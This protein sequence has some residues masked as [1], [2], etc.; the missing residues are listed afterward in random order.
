MVKRGTFVVFALALTGLSACG[1]LVQDSE[2]AANEQIKEVSAAFRPEGKRPDLPIL[3]PDSSYAD[4]LKYALLNSPVVEASYY[5]WA[6]AVSRITVARSLPDPRL[7]FQLDIQRIIPS[8][9]PGVAFDIPGPGKLAA[10]ADMAAAGS[11]GQYQLFIKATLQT[12]FDLQKVCREL[13]FLKVKLDS[14]RESLRLMGEFAQLAETLNAA[15]RGT[16]Q[17]ALRAQIEEDRLRTEIK[18]IEEARQPLLEKFKAVLGLRPEATAPPLPPVLQESPAGEKWPDKILAEA[19][20][21]NPDLKILRA[22]IQL[23][24]ANL[25]MARKGNIPDFSAGASMDVL[26]A[27]VLV[28]PYASMTLPVWR[29]KIAAGIAAAQSSKRASEARLSAA[30]IQLAVQCAEKSYLAREAARNLDVLRGKLLPKAKKALEVSRSAYTSGQVDFLTLLEA[31]RLLLSFDIEEAA[32]VLQHE[33]A[34]AELS[35]LIAGHGPAEASFASPENPG[36]VK[37]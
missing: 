7:T 36:A 33:L 12:A 28:R 24:E 30:Q 17:D 4:F 6:A 18:N 29:D 34:L 15:N 35:M 13:Q 2:K 5:D 16:L 20:A 21:R 19:L 11:E 10:A 27:P 1:L 26:S 14:S 9:M 32:A 22:D 37:K 23:A 31:E 8:F 25:S 3:G